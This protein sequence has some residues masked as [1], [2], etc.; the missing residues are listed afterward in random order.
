MTTSQSCE[1][2]LETIDIGS[3]LRQEIHRAPGIFEAPNWSRDGQFLVINRDGKLYRVAQ[4][5]GEPTLINTD[6]AQAINNDHGISPDG[7]TLV[8]SHHDAAQNG[9]SVIYLLPIDGGTPQRVTQKSPSYWHGWSPDG[10]TLAYVAGRSQGSFKIY[11]IDIAGGPERQ[12]SFGV[13]LDDGPDYS[14]DGKLIYFNSFRSGRMQIWQ[15]NA[16]G[17]EP[18]QLIDSPHS[19]WFPHPSP[20]GQ[21][22]VFLRYLED[23]GEAH[24]FGRSVQLMLVKLKDATATPL[25]EPFFGGQGTINVPSWAPDGRRFAFVSYVAQGR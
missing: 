4:S 20:D 7:T 24:P 13:G 18:R 1:S 23:Q 15:M 17:S 10:Q 12:L 22:L 14:A 21:H 19:D 11:A 25:T 5:G 2:I 16:D 6:F 9:E 3:G 8:I